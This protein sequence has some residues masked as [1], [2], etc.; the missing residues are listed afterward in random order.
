MWRQVCP[1]PACSATLFLRG[2]HSGAAATKQ[3]KQHIK[4]SCHTL[5]TGKITV[6]GEIINIF[7]VC[8]F[9][10]PE[11]SH[12][13][14]FYSKQYRKPRRPPVSDPRDFY[15]ILILFSFLFF[16]FPFS[17][18]SLPQPWGLTSIFLVLLPSGFWLGLANG[19]NWQEVNGQRRG[20][21]GIIFLFGLCHGSGMTV[22]P[23]STG[24]AGCPPARC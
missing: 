7:F 23:M 1:Q 13:S 5:H 8:F 4:L 10:C 17:A 12:Y 14:I 9:K 20:G 19:R 21:W 15:P 3:W 16:P 11:C 18:P 6:S 24:P 2:R 22:S